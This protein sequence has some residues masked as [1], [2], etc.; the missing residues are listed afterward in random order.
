MIIRKYKN[1][2]IAMSADRKTAAACL[3]LEEAMVMLAQMLG[4][5]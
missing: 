4:A 3:S 5:K 2:F 1:W